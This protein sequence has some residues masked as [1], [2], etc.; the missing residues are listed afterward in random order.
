[1]TGNKLYVEKTQVLHCSFRECVCRNE[2]KWS[3]GQNFSGEVFFSVSSYFIYNWDQRKIMS[4]SFL[5]LIKAKLYQLPSNK[6]ICVD[7]RRSS[8]SSA[9]TKKWERDN[10]KLCQ[11][12]S[13]GHVFALW[14]NLNFL[15]VILQ[16]STNVKQ[17]LFAS[18]GVTS[19]FT[20]SQAGDRQYTNHVH[21]ILLTHTMIW[22]NRITEI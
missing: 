16:V 12:D 15:I 3:K 5:I 10:P 8:N 20:V 22:T 11:C 7:I 9:S 1:M 4:M 13:K 14:L 17:V 18:N 2:Q 21:A 19:Y 6:L